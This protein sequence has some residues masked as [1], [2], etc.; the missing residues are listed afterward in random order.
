MTAMGLAPVP[1]GAVWAVK[2]LKD[3]RWVEKMTADKG[4]GSII[5]R[6]FIDL[7][8]AKEEFSS[9]FLSDGR[10]SAWKMQRNGGQ[11]WRL[12]ACWLSLTEKRGGFRI[13]REKSSCVAALSILGWWWLPPSAE[14]RP[15]IL[16]HMW[17][18]QI[19]GRVVHLAPQ[20]PA[21]FLH[22]FNIFVLTKKKG[23]WPA[24]LSEFYGGATF[25]FRTG[26]LAANSAP[27]ATSFL[28]AHTPKL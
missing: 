7:W 2:T 8:E 15:K 22:G 9:S 14:P 17:K 20:T 5:S 19:R 6:L 23:S 28:N 12:M 3:G 16:D 27:S 13:C 24:L 1:H 18:Q 4:T 25:W 11:S 10:P 21:A 26:Q